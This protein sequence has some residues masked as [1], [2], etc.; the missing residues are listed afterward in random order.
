MNPRLTLILLPL[1]PIFLLTIHHFRKTLQQACEVA[2]EEGSATNVFL[3]EHLSSVTQNLD[4][5]KR[6]FN[7]PAFSFFERLNLSENPRGQ[8]CRIFTYGGNFQGLGR[9]VSA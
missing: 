1:I 7:V 4:V 8:H 3:Q 5:K 6:A 2:Q 9:R